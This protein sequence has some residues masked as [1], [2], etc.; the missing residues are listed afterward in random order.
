[1]SPICLKAD[2][3]GLWLH[4]NS[5]QIFRTWVTSMSTFTVSKWN[6]LTPGY[7]TD[8]SE[9]SHQKGQWRNGIS[10]FLVAKLKIGPFLFLP[11]VSLCIE[12]LM[13][14]VSMSS[15]WKTFHFLCLYC[16]WP[17]QCNKSKICKFHCFIYLFILIH[18]FIHNFYLLLPFWI[19][20]LLTGTHVQYVQ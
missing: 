20:R 7:E 15:S 3:W 18:S 6:N 14:D 19:T 11:C 2:V 9:H 8:S 1:M 5:V 17:T 13:D 10:L 4:S 16:S 12:R